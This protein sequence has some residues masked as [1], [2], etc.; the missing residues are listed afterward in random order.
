MRHFVADNHLDSAVT[1]TG[2]VDCVQDYLNAADVFVFPSEFESQGLAPL[3]AMASGIPVIA[4][5]IPGVM[6]MITDG[7]NGRLVD[8]HDEAA[9]IQAMHDVMTE[10]DITKAQ[11]SQAL[12]TVADYFSIAAVT[13]QHLAL[14]KR[15]TQVG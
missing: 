2:Y 3:E 5:R 4:S 14:F 11:V 9:W 13:D 1:F 6:D 10:A 15:L 7:T 12:K 8:T